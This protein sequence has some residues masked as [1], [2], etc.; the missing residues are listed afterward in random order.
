[1]KYGN[2]Q[3]ITYRNEI[4]QNKFN[5]D[6]IIIYNLEGFLKV[7]VDEE[8]S[9]LK[10]NDVIV[11]N[12]D[13]NIS[14]IGNHAF[15]VM[16][17]LNSKELKF[18]FST[19]KYKF[20]CNSSKEFHS[21]YD[22]L[23]KL[24]AEVLINQYSKHSF[25]NIK[26]NQLFYEIILFLLTNFSVEQLEYQESIKD[27]LINYI[28]MHYNED[29]SLQE[30]SRVFHM[31]TQY[32]SKYFKK[33]VG[34][35]F[36]KYVTN[37]R[38]KKAMK[39]VIYSNKRIMT[40]AMDNGFSNINAFN[41]MFKEK[42][43]KTPKEYREENQF[44][45]QD[46]KQHYELAYAIDNL[47]IKPDINNNTITMHVDSYHK[48]SYTS[49]WNKLMNLGDFSLLDNA[50]V[51]NQ[52]KEIQASLKFEY[53]R[54]KLDYQLF[55]KKETYNFIKEEYRFNE[56]YKMKFKIWI[57]IDYR[58]VKDID[59]LCRYLK[60][61]LSFVIG[62]WSIN[63]VQQWYFEIVYNS[64]F[65]KDKPK[66][67]CEFVN[68]IQKTL[69]LYGCEERIVIAGLALWNKKGIHNL[70]QYLEKNHIV[71]K[72]QSFIVEPTAYYQDK[73]GN[74]IIQAINHNDVHSD[75]LS[76]KQNNIYYQNVVENTYI[77]SW[78]DHL[79]LLN[80]MNDSCYKGSLIL[81]NFL[82]CFGQ[83]DA[84]AQNIFLDA[85]YEPELKN[86]VLFG[87]EGLINYHGIKKPSYYAYDFMRI[88]GD[89]FLGR[90]D[91]VGVFMSDSGNY[92]VVAH[93]C[94]SL[95]YRY[96]MEEGNLKE[97]HID[98]YFENNDPIK[99][100]V[101]IKN[102][103]NGKYKIK[104]RFINKKK[105][106]IQD[107]LLH[108]LSSNDLVLHPHDIDFLK[109]I[110]IPYMYLY[111]LVVNDGVIDVDISLESNE[112]ALFHIIREF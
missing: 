14:C 108:M 18:W 40:I 67:F 101:R 44:I 88:V 90:N 11:I 55:Q 64:D 50:Q 63:N 89:W 34:M 17:V 1:M 106:S 112:I 6:I 111:E 39:E 60:S 47:N 5:E 4:I 103:K 79:Q 68:Q 95:N 93:N 72:N 73:N 29:L 105:G 71:F 24:L 92:Q 38:L 20:I 37:I 27:K 65:T 33:H 75:I 82:Q 31:S 41:H 43:G 19:H 32:F 52:L 48:S 102:C 74:E 12:P 83:M 98:D 35:Q 84:I 7:I 8:K 49:F 42:Y 36:F 46:S 22:K 15:Y 76:L 85:I 25:M 26:L 110:S 107:E 16:Y 53:I 59:Y 97:V 62:Q 70:F 30:M 78:R 3:C 99:L 56:L 96:Y 81:Y 9:E 45:L 58:E 23:R 69:K 54:I 91:N 77:V 87:G 21:N 57:T 66:R 94:K 2:I 100:N 80:I 61:L 86:K 13:S 109:S 10:V 104:K 51:L 28:E